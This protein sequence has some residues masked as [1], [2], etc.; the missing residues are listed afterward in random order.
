[1]TSGLFSSGFKRTISHSEAIIK[2]FQYMENLPMLLQYL[3]FHLLAYGGHDNGL[4]QAAI[5]ESGGPL[6]SWIFCYNNRVRSKFQLTI[7][8]ESCTNASDTIA[9][10]RAAA[11][12]ALNAVF[13]TIHALYIVDDTFIT[14]YTSIS[15]SK[16]DFVKV[17]LLVGT[18]TGERKLFAGHGVN[19]T[20]E[21]RNLLQT[22]TYI[23]KTNKPHW[24]LL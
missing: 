2:E 17:P 9:Y 1:M 13:K 4:F 10:F 24:M 11:F 8:A 15:L 23:R 21:F 6:L 12:D 14:E 20:A 5:C 7:T 19:T 22:K 3:G 18:S 16:G